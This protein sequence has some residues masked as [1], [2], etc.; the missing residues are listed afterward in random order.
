ML[1]FK[2]KILRLVSPLMNSSRK[3]VFL[4]DEK[5][6]TIQFGRDSLAKVSLCPLKENR[7]SAVEFDHIKLAKSPAAVPVMGGGKG[8]VPRF[9]K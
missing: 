8:A 7:Q 4:L 3:C 6:R 1:N 9:S 2:V 5:A